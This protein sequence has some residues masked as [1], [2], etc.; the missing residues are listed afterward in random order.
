VTEGQPQTTYDQSV[1]IDDSLWPIVLIT[2][3]AR[4]FTDDEFLSHLDDLT[5]CCTREKP[6][7]HA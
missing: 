6:A 7:L 3:T 4:D 1:R 2:R 5:R